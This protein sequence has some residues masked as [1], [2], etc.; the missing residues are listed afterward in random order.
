MIA[1]VRRPMRLWSRCFMPL[2]VA[3]ALAIAATA[4]AQERPGRGPATPAEQKGPAN[5]GV[6][7]LLPA[8]S[9]TPHTLDTGSRKLAYTATAG[10]F[11]LYRQNGER[12]A[13]IFY[14]AYVLN[15]ALSDSRPLTFVFNGG[16]GAA[17]TYLHLGLVGPKILDFGPDG[18]DGAAARLRSNP[19][20][21]LEFTDL[22]M[23]DPVGTGWSRAAKADEAGNFWGVRQDAQSL[24]KTVA[25]YVNR[26][27]RSASP[28]YLLGESYGGFRAMKIARALQEEQGIVTAGIIMVSPLLEAALQFG[29]NRFALGAALQLPSLAAAELERRRAFTPEALAEAEHFAMTDYLTTLAGPPPQG[30]AAERFYARVAEM[31]GLP[32][33]VVTK[34]RG[35][36]RDSYVKRLR[37]TDGMVVSPYDAT[38]A[39]PD[40]Y[41][42][43]ERARGDDPILDGFTR[44]Y[45]GAFAA[46]A[47]EEL[48]FKTDMTYIL[49]AR[50]ASGKWDWGHDGGGSRALASVTGDMR[51][52]L[53]LNPAFR[54]LIVH[55]YAD[56]VTPYAV[57]RYVLNHLPPIG[58]PNRA[59]LKLYPGGHMPYLIPQSRL[60]L[61]ADARAFYRA[62]LD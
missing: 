54:L 37:E 53:A 29:A 17:S 45:G 16:P 61:T 4:A 18:R 62:L 47:R 51:E 44:A 57:S 35:F 43:S 3:I 9:V 1:H 40:A 8:D 60:A 52:Y 27:G 20:S 46:Y 49:L 13:A 26:N 41:P 2:A 24:A 5:G 19:Q 58:A 14:T 6:L 11:N 36:V 42:D 25:L 38:F 23:I 10:T 22:V 12:S 21:W 31:T 50:E 30:E 55:G 32:V 59:Q 33:D 7:S 56:L 28:K 34:T 15:D 48:G 39:A